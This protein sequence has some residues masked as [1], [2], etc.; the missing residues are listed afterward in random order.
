M[1]RLT[2]ALAVL[3][4]IAACSG[5]DGDG[6]KPRVGDDSEIAQINA[7]NG[8]P[9]SK[10]PP[11][12]PV[13]VVKID[14][15]PP[16][17]PQTAI[18]KADLVVEQTV[19]GG[20]TRLAALYW[21]KLPKKLGHVRSLR[22]TDIGIAQSVDGQIVASGGAGGVIKKI[23]KA[24]ITMRTEDDGA[25]GF[26]SDVGSRPYNRLVDL[27]AIA[28]KAKGPGPKRTY[29]EW[30]DTSAS[31]K[32]KKDTSASPAAPTESAT[33]AAVQ[34][35]RAHTTNWAFNDGA[36][37][38]TNG[39]S[40]KEFAAKNLIVIEA[41]ER[42]AGYRDPAGA[43]VPETHFVGT[44]SFVLFEGKNVIK[45]TWKKAKR[46]STITLTDDQGAAVTMKPGKTW[47]ELVNE[48]RGSTT[49]K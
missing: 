44:G 46:N 6:K 26:S 28:A 36:W 17:A 3:L 39:T 45:G 30:S 20:V 23:S 43:P 49:W 27:T 38:R 29:F 8:T 14:N 1:R 24:G 34:F 19:E 21:S 41:T 9:L 35:S 25:P 42:D 33:S 5:K 12:H 22:G 11:K 40:V 13:F 31:G 10:G 47:V 4:L 18:D 15:T 37:K 48:G 32:E 16:S 2:A 7:L